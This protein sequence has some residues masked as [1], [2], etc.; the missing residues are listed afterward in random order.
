MTVGARTARPLRAVVGAEA[1]RW[2]T[3]P[4][5]R[6]IAVVARTVTSVVR[7]LETLPA[8]VRGDPRIAVV[9]AHDPASAFQDGV[10]RLLEEN[11]CRVLPA[12][13]L[14]EIR[15]DLILSASENV[16]AETGSCPVLVLPHGVG[17][18]KLV[19]ARRG[20]GVRVS[21]VV[22]DRLLESGRAWLAL[23]HPDQRAQLEESHPA[24]RNRTLLLGDPCFDELRASLPRASAFRRRLGVPD[25]KR[26]VVLSSTWGRASLL[27]DDPRLPGRVLARLPFDEYRVAAILH[28]N[29]WA[30]HGSWQIRALLAPA[31]D[32]GL[33]LMPT[34]HAW[35]AAL[36]AADVVVGDHGSVTLYGAALGKPTL[37][38]AFGAG[39]VVPG[40]A[41]DLL[42]RAA[43]R[44]DGRRDLIAQLELALREQ[45]PEHYAEVRD[46]A[47]AEPGSAVSRLRSAVYRLL[48]LAE[49]P[50]PPPRGTVS[51]SGPRATEVRSWLVTT[52][53][54][55]REGHTV[56]TTRRHPAPAVEAHEEAYEG[57]VPEHGPVRHLASREDEPDER[58]VESASVVLGEEAA[59]DE[60]AAG[61]WIAATLRRLPGSLAAA[62]ALASPGRHLVGLRD[63]RLVEAS[64]DLGPEETG[65]V[66]ALVYAL[67]RAEATPDGPFLLRSTPRRVRPVRLRI[68]P[69]ARAP[70]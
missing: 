14:A 24:S 35:R 36:V 15:P 70:R 31:L 7:V 48:D 61:D 39:E 49:P 5:E 32:A 69:P 3:F 37:L 65:L 63:G 33:L 46:A 58:L 38:G 12:S 68:S 2:R 26:L 53:L 25:G 27:G 18:Q 40:T 30:A 4:Q 66:A 1:A 59:R 29:V 9:F 34:V 55:T 60:R 23:S 42:G 52:S 51:V 50:S 17:F 16:P 22:S 19:P 43:P 64:G 13:R 10:L 57:V 28:P 45:G 8:V 6:T 44:L 20:S 21:G 62:V 56:V 67:L 11:D 54:S 41:V 47:F